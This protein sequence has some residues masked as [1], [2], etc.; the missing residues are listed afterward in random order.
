M[1]DFETKNAI[2]KLSCKLWSNYWQS[3]LFC[4]HSFSHSL[5]QI[6]V[7]GIE[8]VKQKRIH[9]VSVYNI[10]ENEMAK[11]HPDFFL[12]KKITRINR[13]RKFAL[14]F[15]VFDGWVKISNCKDNFLRVQR[16]IGMAD[17]GITKLDLSGNELDENQTAEIVAMLNHRN[18]QLDELNLDKNN[19][20][21]HSV[22]N[23]IHSLVDKNTSIMTISLR[24][25]D[26]LEFRSLLSQYAIELAR[27][28]GKSI[29]LE[30]F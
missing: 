24:Q 23:I 15:E 19:F 6:E 9:L 22:K 11:Q 30:M 26:R 29:S 21:G 5:D 8:A 7:F 14:N 4:W 17:N 1:G 20:D 27:E 13:A 25:N 10:L 3:V 2:R 28:S 12:T 18:C 16:L